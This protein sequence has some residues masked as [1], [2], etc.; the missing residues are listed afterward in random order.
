MKR[1]LEGIEKLKQNVD[2]I[3]V[4]PNQQLIKTEAKDLNYDQ[5]FIVADHVLCSGIQGITQLI[6]KEGRPNLDFADITSVLKNQGEKILGRGVD[7]V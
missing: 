3:I 5:S 1:A 7:E 6:T 4:I 2:S